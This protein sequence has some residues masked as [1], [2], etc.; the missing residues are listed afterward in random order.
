[1]D[2]FPEVRSVAVL[3]AGLSGI[4]AAAHLLRAGLDVTVFERADCAGGA[5]VYSAD[6]ADDPPYP[7][8]GPSVS[9]ALG[10]T[11]EPTTAEA[12]K[13]QFAPPGP[14]YDNMCSRNS[15]AVMRTTLLNWPP[16]TPGRMHH[17]LVLAYLRE[18][19]RVHGVEERV[20]YSTRV[21]SV[22]KEHSPKRGW[23]VQTSRWDAAG[24]SSENNSKTD[25]FDAVVV[26]TGRYGE[27]RVPDIAGLPAWKRACP[28]RITHAKQYRKP[29]PFRGKTVF[30]VG[31]FI[32]ALEITRQLLDAGVAHVY[33]SARATCFDFRDKVSDERAEKVCMAAEFLLSRADQVGEE[34]EGRG[35]TPLDDNDAIPGA[36][37]LQDGRRLTGIDHVILATGYVTSFPFLRGGGE[38][39]QDLEQPLTPLDEAGDRVLVTADGR[40]VHNLHEDLF[41]IPD[42]T[43]AFVGVTQFASTFSLYDIQAQAVAAVL[44]GRLR[45]PPQQAMQALQMRR[46]QGLR[47]GMQL[48]SIFLTDDAVIRRLLAWGGGLL[49]A[50]DAAWWAAFQEERDKAQASLSAPGELRKD[51]CVVVARM[52]R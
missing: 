18:M 15:T 17:S 51:G 35:E 41:Y 16:G 9:R 2:G 23:T 14:V 38:L 52:H 21:E 19:A 46:K 22:R 25:T 13:K 29:D 31:A 39:G 37:V 4:L 50:P 30:V 11:P 43:L 5:W 36:V 12:R 24:G 20:R 10:E 45:L 34:V 1:M 3:G 32:S 47:P 6:P 27:P 8:T 28:G 42:P 44:S 7:N 48:N 33:M 26:A 49:T 40:T